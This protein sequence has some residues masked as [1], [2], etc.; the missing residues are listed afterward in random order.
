M[1]RGLPDCFPFD[2]IGVLAVNVM[3]NLNVA[4]CHGA[5]LYLVVGNHVDEVFCVWESHDFL[6]FPC[7]VCAL[8]V[9][10][11]VESFL[12]TDTGDRKKSA[13]VL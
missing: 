2:H 12:S 11:R 5:V 1:A 8:D 10:I 6:G 9:E 7:L 13:I 3:C 4:F